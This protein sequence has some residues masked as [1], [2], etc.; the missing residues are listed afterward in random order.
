MNETIDE[1]IEVK[2][3]KKSMRD[4]TPADW[5]TEARKVW[6]MNPL[7]AI[8]NAT[9]GTLL[10]NKFALSWPEMQTEFTTVDMPD[11]SGNVAYI[12]HMVFCEHGLFCDAAWKDGAIEDFE[13]L[14]DRMRGSHCVNGTLRCVVELSENGLYAMFMWLEVLP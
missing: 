3:V 7:V 4:F 2:E 10:L 14:K 5:A 13:Q 12:E 11:A 1:K 8:A 9:L 6:S